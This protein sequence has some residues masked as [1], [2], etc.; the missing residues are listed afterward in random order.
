MKFGQ[1]Q[2]KVLFSTFPLA[3]GAQEF[4]AGGRGDLIFGQ[5][6][7][8]LDRP[9]HLF[10]MGAAAGTAVGMFIEGGALFRRER[11]FKIFGDQFYQFLAG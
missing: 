2:I 7:R 11:T 5:F 6:A 10:Q 9:T 3:E 1:V 8:E 4:I